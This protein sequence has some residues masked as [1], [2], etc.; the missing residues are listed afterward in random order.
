MFVAPESSLRERKKAKTRAKIVEEALRLF[1]DQGYHQTTIAQIAE[2]SE[3]S[4][5]TVSTATWRSTGR[6]CPAALHSSVAWSASDSV[7]HPLADAMSARS[8]SILISH[9]NI[10]PLAR[11]TLSVHVQGR[12]NMRKADEI[13]ARPAEGLVVECAT[14][15]PR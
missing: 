4:P 5:R 15:E 2:A 1:A 12:R 10:R 6:S 13:P 9:L 11:E 7:M 14:L 3:V 8:I